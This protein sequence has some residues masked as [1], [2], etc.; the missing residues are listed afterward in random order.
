M[1]KYSNQYKIWGSCTNIP[2]TLVQII[3]LL[4]QMSSKVQFHP[5]RLKKRLIYKS[6]YMYYFI[7]KDAVMAAM[8]W[9]KE[10]NPLYADVTISEDWDKEWMDSKFVS[11]IVNGK[12]CNNESDDSGNDVVNDDDHSHNVTMFPLDAKKLEEDTTAENKCLETVGE[13]LPNALEV[14]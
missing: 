9:L 6:S 11:F 12:D 7:R 10:N 5:M 13:P 4:P 1:H 8:K 2:A 3:T 14:E